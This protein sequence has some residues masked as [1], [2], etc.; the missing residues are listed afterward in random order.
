MLE[1]ILYGKTELS[2]V[3]T[4]EVG[5]VATACTVALAN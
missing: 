1:V 2:G 5:C 3:A 4:G